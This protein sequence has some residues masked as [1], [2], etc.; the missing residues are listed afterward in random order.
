MINFISIRNQYSK[1]GVLLLNPHYALENLL[2]FEITSKY[3][4]AL[5]F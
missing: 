1:S 2:Q 4:A 3:T 5:L